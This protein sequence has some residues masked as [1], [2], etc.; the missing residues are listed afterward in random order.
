MHSL[1]Q[2]LTNLLGYTALMDHPSASPEQRAEA[3]AVVQRAA[4]ELTDL[5]AAASREEP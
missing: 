2:P 1:R 3:V 5:V 4:Q